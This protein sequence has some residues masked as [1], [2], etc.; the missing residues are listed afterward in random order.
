MFRLS[1]VIND[2]IMNRHVHHVQF[3]ECLGLESRLLV[4]INHIQV[5]ADPVFPAQGLV[6][7]PNNCCVISLDHDLSKQYAAAGLQTTQTA[8]FARW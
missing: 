2:F 8:L 7:W 3:V 1:Q 6:G 5:L 4:P